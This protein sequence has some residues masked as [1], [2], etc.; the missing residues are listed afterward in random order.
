[1]IKNPEVA[2]HLISVLAKMNQHQEA[3]RIYDE[4]KKKYPNNQILKNLKK[5]L[6]ADL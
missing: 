2:S 5:V 6:H 3:L 4:M 1:L